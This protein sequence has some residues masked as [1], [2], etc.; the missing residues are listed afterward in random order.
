VL[1]AVSSKGISFATARFIT[2]LKVKMPTNASSSTTRAAFLASA[3][4]IAV[5]RMLVPGPTTTAF[6]LART[7]LRV[8]TDP[9]PFIVA[10]S[11]G[12]SS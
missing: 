7:V 3:I 6:L 10:A 1:T 2:S 12:P 8:G 11:K 5:S 9:S 4:S